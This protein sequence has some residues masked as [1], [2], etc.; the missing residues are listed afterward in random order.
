M[1]QI[2]TRIEKK[3]CDDPRKGVCKRRELGYSGT[4]VVITW[5]AAEEVRMAV[6]WA[7]ARQPLPLCAESPHPNPVP[8]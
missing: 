1:D 5:I 6:Y 8:M 4:Q 7:A 2:Q 3:D